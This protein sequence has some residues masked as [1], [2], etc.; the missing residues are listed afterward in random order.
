MNVRSQWRQASRR[1]ALA[2]ITVA[3][4][5]GPPAALAHD[6]W[7]ERIDGPAGQP[8]PLAL[9]TGTHF[10]RYEEPVQPKVVAHLA[11]TDATGKAHQPEP[12]RVGRRHTVLRV[13]GLDATA[14]SCV[15]RLQPFEIELTPALVDVYFEEI[16]ASEALRA[17]AMQ[18]RAQ[19]RSFQERYL[20]V[21]RIEGTVAPP[22]TQAQPLDVLRVAPAGELKAGAEVVFEVQRDGKP[23]PDQP[24]QML[25]EALPAGLW[26]RTD[27][28]GR[29]RLRLPLPG[30]WLLRG[31]DLRPP[32]SEGARWE[33]R[34]IAYTF[35][36]AR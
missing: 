33:S 16:R 30:R 25:N 14:F 32:A 34:F 22:R 36:A 13:P 7:F 2:A 27:A 20:K 17:I 18:Q 35:E 28:G 31:V 3:L 21:A 5:A 24:V 11:C 15:A 9:G 10:P 4:L 1:G 6:T 23:L 19:G 29:I 26:A 8:L 12:A